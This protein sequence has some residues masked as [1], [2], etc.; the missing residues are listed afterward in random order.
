MPNCPKCHTFI[1][2]TRVYNWHIYKHEVI[3]AQLKLLYRETLRRDTKTEN[4]TNHEK[5]K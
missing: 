4:K 5:E 2:N 1:R 3:D